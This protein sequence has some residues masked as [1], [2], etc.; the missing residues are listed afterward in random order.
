MLLLVAG[1]VG[2]LY[3]LRHERVLDLGPHIP[4]ALPLEQLAGEASQPLARMAVAWLPTGA[5]AGVVLMVLT[6]SRASVRLLG[7]T[8]LS[9]VVLFLTTAASDA[10][11]Q[12]ERLLDHLGAPLAR[13]GVWAAVL[14]VITGSLLA[15]IALGASPRASG[16]AAAG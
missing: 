14:L 16:A 4:G 1:G 9:F 8:L 2:W 15:E 5:A 3:L 11:A 6:R 10:V 7:L 13:G 12:N